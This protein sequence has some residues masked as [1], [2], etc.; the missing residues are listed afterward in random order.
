MTPPTPRL[1]A[2]VPLERPE[3]W[4]LGRFREQA[5]SSSAPHPHNQA[6]AEANG[7]TSEPS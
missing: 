7:K 5:T 1:P 3:T 2:C 4:D 6:A